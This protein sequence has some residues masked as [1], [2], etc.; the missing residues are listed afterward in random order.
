M[1]AT[2]LTFIATLGHTQ[3]IDIMDILERGIVS[4]PLRHF[5][6]RK[7]DRIGFASGEGFLEKSLHEAAGTGSIRR[8]RSRLTPSHHPVAF[9]MP[10]Q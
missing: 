4:H 3:Y 10:L 9:P 5:F 6:E 8:P 7:R 2:F 1:T